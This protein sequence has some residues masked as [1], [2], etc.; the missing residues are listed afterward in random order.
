MEYSDEL[1]IKKIKR[2]IAI[3]F[4]ISSFVLI[5][6]TGYVDLKNR[7]PIDKNV[8]AY[9]YLTDRQKI[10]FHV[11]TLD[12]KIDELNKKLMEETKCQK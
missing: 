1:A 12:K 6:Y 7:P 4:I 9:N 5:A 2:T 11:R 3:I 8:E 10:L